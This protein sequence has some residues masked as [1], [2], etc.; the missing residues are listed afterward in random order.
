MKAKNKNPL[1]VVKGDEVQPASGVVDLLIKKL[2]I[3]PVIDMLMNLFKMLFE[4]VNSYAGFMVIKNLFDELMNRV[5][6]FKRFSI[7]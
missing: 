7:L 3:E 5:E 4:A 2:N 6:L 1:Y